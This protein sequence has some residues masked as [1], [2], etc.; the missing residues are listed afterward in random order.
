VIFTPKDGSRA[1]EYKWETRQVTNSEG[2][3]APQ[4]LYYLQATGAEYG[5]TQLANRLRVRLLD[6]AG[7]SEHCGE[8]Q[9]PR[10]P[11]SEKVPPDG[12]P[13]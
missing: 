13:P 3:L 5:P 2:K 1:L 6:I 8:P 7:G 10:P 12:L 4:T 9:P 11:V